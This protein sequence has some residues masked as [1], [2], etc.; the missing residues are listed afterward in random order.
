MSIT[1]QKSPIPKIKFC[2][3]RIWIHFEILCILHVWNF[4]F[5]LRKGFIFFET[6]NY[7]AWP[8][9]PVHGSIGSLRFP[10]PP[11][12]VLSVRDVYLPKRVDPSSGVSSSRDSETSSFQH[13]SPMTRMLVHG[14]PIARHHTTGCPI[15]TN[16]CPP[17]SASCSV[18]LS[19][20]REYQI[21]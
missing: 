2:K 16:P 17:P 1:W 5:D 7:Q 20:T 12:Y 10:S 8:D 21:R 19:A 18:R 6:G 15:A 13:S 4:K 9:Q 11:K 3:K 14:C